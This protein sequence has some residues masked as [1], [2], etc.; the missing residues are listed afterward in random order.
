MDDYHAFMNT[1][2]DE[3]NHS[4]QGDGC[5]GCLTTTFLWI[6]AAFVFLFFVI[7]VL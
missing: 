2:D 6:L 1:Q 7:M 3:N 4:N 5:F